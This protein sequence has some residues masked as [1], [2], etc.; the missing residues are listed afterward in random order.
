MTYKL[1]VLSIDDNHQN[2]SL[3]QQA[4][5]HHFDIVS[6][7]GEESIDELVLDCE[8][9]IILLDIM[10]NQS[11]G[12]DICRNI[13]KLSLSKQVIVIFVSSLHSLEDK[14]KAYE[15]GGDDYICKPVNLTELECK[16]EAY[17]KHIKVQNQ[18][19]DKMQEA[20]QAAFVS[21]Q[22]S[23]ELGLLIGF[24]T[25]SL[26]IKNLDE[27]FEATHSAVSSFG[28]NCVLEFRIAKSSIQYP[29]EQVS[30]LESEI[31][32]LGKRAKRIV[33]F[34]HNVLFN[35][36]QCSLLIKRMPDDELLSG[37]MQD[38]LATLLE[39]I[40]SR[41]L[42]F[43][44][45]ENCHNERQAAIMTVKMAVKSDFDST[46]GQL[47]HKLDQILLNLESTLSQKLIEL[48]ASREHETLVSSVVEQTKKQF[49]LIT[50][51][52][53]DIDKKIK[54]IS[55]LLDNVKQC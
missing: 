4:L 2:L 7:S 46:F 12:Y 22:Q 54:N 31:L 42:F 10:L 13:R 47:D 30:H 3:I 35:S 6:S 9:D 24:F 27:L 1:R 5:E 36:R 41:V 49:S 8:P 26:M 29:K 34:G 51:N 15:A 11:N 17:E 23:S 52:S 53:S 33:P 43:Q 55:Q 44:N 39:I 28:L 18:L 32:E 37:R 38:H 20:S 40:N 50:V 25:Q 19:K 45:E 16:L 21:M 14:L 48:G